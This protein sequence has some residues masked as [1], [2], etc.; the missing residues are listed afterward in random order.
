MSM[1]C[2][3]RWNPLRQWFKYRGRL[4]FI[5]YVHIRIGIHTDICTVGN[6]GSLDRLDYTTIGNGVNLAS[7]LE[8]SAEANQILISEATHLLVMDQIKCT[9]LNK[10]SVKNIR[11]PIQTYSVDGIKNE[12]PKPAPF[13]MSTKE[14][15]VKISPSDETNIAEQKEILQQAIAYLNRLEE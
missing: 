9:K 15:L 3:I 14:L 10:V 13:E 8:A 5:L 4:L 7:R 12:A 1:P 2:G 6:F 11:D